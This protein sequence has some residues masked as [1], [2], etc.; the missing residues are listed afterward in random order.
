MASALIGRL[1]RLKALGSRN[2]SYNKILSDMCLDGDLCDDLMFAAD[3]DNVMFLEGGSKSLISDYMLRHYVFLKEQFHRYTNQDARRWQ[4]MKNQI[5]HPNSHCNS[6]SKTLST[7]TNGNNKS[8]GQTNAGHDLLV[9]AVVK[10]ENAMGK[11]QSW[12][13]VPPALSILDTPCFEQLS[14]QGL[15]R[16]KKLMAMRKAKEAMQERQRLRLRALEENRRRREAE[17][18]QLR[19]RNEKY[20]DADYLVQ[21]R[22]FHE[23][24]N[25]NNT[26][27][28]KN[29]TDSSND[30]S[31]HGPNVPVNSDFLDLDTKLKQW[32]VP[33]LEPPCT[34][35]PGVFDTVVQ[36]SGFFEMYPD[37]KG[38]GNRKWDIWTLAARAPYLGAENDRLSQVEQ[39]SDVH[40]QLLLELVQNAVATWETNQDQ[41]ASYGE[42][43]LT[44]FRDDPADPTRNGEFREMLEA[45][46]QHGQIVWPE[47]LRRCMR[48]SFD[49]EGNCNTTTTSA[50]VSGNNLMK[51]LEDPISSSGVT[52][53]LRIL[54]SISSK[55]QAN[56]FKTPVVLEGSIGEMYR[57]QVTDPMDLG[58]IHNNL[59]SG[60]YGS[61]LDDNES[62]SDVSLSDK[63]SGEFKLPKGVELFQKHMKLVFSNCIDF[64]SKIIEDLDPKD[65][66]LAMRIQAQREELEN[67]KEIQRS[68]KIKVSKAYNNKVKEL[69]AAGAD[70]E[71][72]IR[73]ALQVEAE[74]AA[75]EGLVSEGKTV[76]GAP[77]W[78]YPAVRISAG[79]IV[80]GEPWLD[81]TMDIDRSGL[82]GMISSAKSLLKMF[83]KFFEDHVIRL[84]KVNH[85]V[86]KDVLNLDTFSQK[87]KS[88]IK[89]R[90]DAMH[91]K[92]S[93]A[94]TA[95]K[96]YNST[97][98][99]GEALEAWSS[100]VDGS[101][102]TD[103]SDIRALDCKKLMAKL[104]SV[105]IAA[106][107]GKLATN[108]KH[109]LPLTTDELCFT[110]SWLLNEVVGSDAWREDMV[111][112][113]ASRPSIRE[114][115]TDNIKR[116]KARDAKKQR[117][118]ECLEQAR[119]K[120]EKTQRELS[121]KAS[122]EMAAR[123]A[124]GHRVSTRAGL[125]Q[126]D[127]DAKINDAVEHARAAFWEDESEFDED[128]CDLPASK[129]EAE[130][131]AREQYEETWVKVSPLG[132]D[133]HGNCYWSFPCLRSSLKRSD[134]PAMLIV[135]HSRSGALSTYKDEASVSQ[136]I[137]SL[138]ARGKRESKLIQNI[139]R[140][141]H[142]IVAGIKKLNEFAIKID[143]K[144]SYSTA[145]ASSTASRKYFGQIC[146]ALK[147]IATDLLG[148]TDVMLTSG[149]HLDESLKNAFAHPTAEGCLS[150]AKNVVLSIAASADASGSIPWTEDI[151]KQI[152]R[153]SVQ[154]SNTF[155]Q[156]VFYAHRLVF[157]Q[158]QKMTTGGVELN[159][160]VAITQMAFI[161]ECGICKYCLDKPKVSA[162][163][164]CKCFIV[165]THTQA[166]THAQRF[167][168]GEKIEMI[169]GYIGTMHY[170]FFLIY[171]ILTD[172]VIKPRPLSP[173]ITYSLDTLQFGGNY[174]L[175]QACI[176]RQNAK[177]ALAAERKASLNS[178]KKQKPM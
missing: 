1:Q 91:A 113:R 27:E 160:A 65:G 170:C 83:N 24:K 26:V 20:N 146:E 33:C 112:R 60:L 62:D 173:Y 19:R 142:N 10:Q 53:C 96:Q 178:L 123:V 108:A 43:A 117:L 50:N 75:V 6:E 45:L 128:D 41:G 129:E 122:A 147:S 165:K 31:I 21:I 137:D 11:E 66:V 4:V 175:R 9:N 114:T 89:T 130:E 69:R 63:V 138:L 80:N 169:L 57:K 115:R 150:A 110:L 125:S 85:S 5:K 93:K 18:Q 162:S 72:V 177:K 73:A 133:R 140:L 44:I 134:T 102:Y 54:E 98:F 28:P 87:S 158:K 135:E 23:N 22:H 105:E 111:T 103:S 176:L 7:D 17:A 100:T 145:S 95:A 13:F 48:S 172:V 35:S 144:R 15:R 148:K 131:L 37:A 126:A 104:W 47:I 88:A 109:N 106:G 79:E 171:W 59:K 143:S 32:P 101:A 56:L 118:R 159:Q 38:H 120:A 168:S 92:M 46:Q 167:E 68:K 97:T 164:N 86:S 52:L 51:H 82:T 14:Y 39:F 161:G 94:A 34:L 139:E 81:D 166:R 74:S 8:R 121:E 40:I 174:T 152:W 124:A 30:L 127:I 163:K 77:N 16:V 12:P 29:S 70:E 55:E 49:N 67:R 25:N 78:V 107:Q 64:W 76:T 119:C 156:I 36:L 99:L 154:C 84:L 136:L 71:T 153:E 90:M 2:I 116:I 61:S 58:T 3:G 141:R 157:F 132:V 155:S 42:T 149:G 151:H